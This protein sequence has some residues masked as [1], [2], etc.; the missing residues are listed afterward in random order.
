MRI[1]AGTMRLEV[2][3]VVVVSNVNLERLIT[4]AALAC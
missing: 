4:Q 3:V 2:V 1:Q